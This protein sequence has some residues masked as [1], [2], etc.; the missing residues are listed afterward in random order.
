[1][2]KLEW[3]KVGERLFETGLD[4]GILFP[5]KGSLY[6]KGAAWN[7]LRTFEQNP[8][9]GEATALYADNTKYLNLMSNEDFAGTIGAYTYPDEF[10]PCNGVVAVKPGMMF[11][12]QKRETFGFACR[13][14]IG[15]DTEDTSY[16]YRLHLVYGMLASPSQKTN[17]TVNDSRSA[18]E[19]SWSF[20]TT[21][22]AI[23]T[24]I[25]G[26][27]LKP[28]AHLYFDST[29]VNPEF[30]AK[31]EEILIGTD[32]EESR[33]PLPDEVISLYNEIAAKG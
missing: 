16:G 31:L 30:L 3:D 20:T 24:K 33:L 15:N 8:S 14:L 21:P 23:E 18:I 5:M 12:G 26:K 2:S 19:L 13:T 29:K 32:T 10:E 22:I 1:M 4:H 7:G 28:T 17:E 9:G 25:D 6:Q 27:A 11:T